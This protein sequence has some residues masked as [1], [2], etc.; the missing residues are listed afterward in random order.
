MAVVGA[1]GGVGASTIAHNLGWAVARD[2]QMDA[3]VT[4]L[5]LAFGTAGL[6]FNQDPP[7][8]VVDAVMSPERID[9]AFIDRL[10]SKCRRS[11]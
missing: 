8:G 5:D 2:F 9:T 3:V 4:D 7:Q 1:K 11:T 6:D 10:L